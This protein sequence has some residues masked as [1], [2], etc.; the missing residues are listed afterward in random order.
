M[1]K[2]LTHKNEKQ[3][4]ILYIR[5]SFYAKQYCSLHFVAVSEV[6][7]LV[8]IMHTKK[9]YTFN[10]ETNRVKSSFHKNIYLSFI[11]QLALIFY[12]LIIFSNQNGLK[13]W[14]STGN[15]GRRIFI[16]HKRLR[17]VWTC[18]ANLEIYSGNFF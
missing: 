7:V 2:R 14:S 5:F 15:L 11:I 8:F 13:Y 18:L 10:K 17:T 1:K 16:V 12:S 9:V 3:S 4:I 6:V